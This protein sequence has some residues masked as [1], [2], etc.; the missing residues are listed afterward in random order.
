MKFRCSCQNNHGE[1]YVNKN[2]DISLTVRAI[3]LTIIY[4]PSFMI[5]TFHWP[6]ILAVCADNVLTGWSMPIAQVFRSFGP[7]SFVLTLHG[8]C[9]L[10]VHVW[11]SAYWS[12]TFLQ[13]H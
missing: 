8:T 9:H 10:S 12:H 2:A 5:V 11:W 7:H 4:P 6:V 13:I 3:R 1:I